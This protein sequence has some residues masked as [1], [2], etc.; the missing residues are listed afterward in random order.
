VTKPELAGLPRMSSFSEP[1]VK[2]TD[3]EVVRTVLAGSTDEFAMLVDR[4]HARALRVAVHI[5]GDQDMAEDAV[6]S[7]FLRAYRYLGGYDE[8]DRFSAWFMRIVIN[9]RRTISRSEGQRSKF[10]TESQHSPVQ[11]GS[12]FSSQE[13]PVDQ[14][15]AQESRIRLARALSQLPSEQREAIVLRFADE[16]SYQEIAEVTG[17]GISALKMRVKRGCARLRD[18]LSEAFHA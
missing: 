9:R 2:P 17:S 3:A 10:A 4:H 12:A 18:L 5:L 14:L 6:Q 15:V 7:A 1:E 16:L 8:R 11:A 13:L